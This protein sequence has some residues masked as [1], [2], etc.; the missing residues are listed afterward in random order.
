[1][2]RSL[3]LTIGRSPPCVHLVWLSKHDQTA[4][5]ERPLDSPAVIFFD[6]RLVLTFA[7]GPAGLGTIK[8]GEKNIAS[9][10]IRAVRAL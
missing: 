8:F 2:G 1:M 7:R 3:A 6:V 5:R 9:D 4:R 10:P